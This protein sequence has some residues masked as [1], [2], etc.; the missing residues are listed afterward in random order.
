MDL[1]I[2]VIDAGAHTIRAGRAE[3][4]PANDRSPH[5]ALPSVVRP[6]GVDDADS[7][8][9]STSKVWPPHAAQRT[10]AAMLTQ[11]HLACAHVIP[12]LQL[13]T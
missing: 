3:D 4:F 1:D 7:T 6:A 12:E 9:T 8:Q 11:L 10:E 5:V 2:F 13:H